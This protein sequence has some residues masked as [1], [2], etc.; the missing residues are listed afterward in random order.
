[1]RLGAQ[2]FPSFAARLK[3]DQKVYEELFRLKKD[4]LDIAK[5]DS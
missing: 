5:I 2:Q 1:V 3:L 4:V